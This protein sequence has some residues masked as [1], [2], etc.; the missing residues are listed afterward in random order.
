MYPI[1]AIL[2]V[3]PRSPQPGKRCPTTTCSSA[4][5]LLLAVSLAAIAFAWRARLYNRRLAPVTRQPRRQRRQPRPRGAGTNDPA[6]CA[7]PRPHGRVDAA[8]TAPARLRCRALR[9]RSCPTSTRRCSTRCEVP[10]SHPS[11]EPP[12]AAGAAARHRRRGCGTARFAR[13][14]APRCAAGRGGAGTRADPAV[15]HAARA[16]RRARTRARRA[17]RRSAARGD[18][19][20]P[21]ASGFCRRARSAFAAFAPATWRLGQQSALA[22]AAF[23]RKAGNCAP[24]AAHVLGL[25]HALGA[26]TVFRLALAHLPGEPESRA[27]SRSARAT[28]HGARRRGGACAGGRLEPA[29]RAALGSR[30]TQ[31]AARAGRDEPARARALRRAAARARPRSCASMARWTRRALASC[32]RARD[33]TTRTGSAPARGSP[34]RAVA[35]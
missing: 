18:R 32:W 15:G 22:A 13:G 30:G 21:A 20:R 24:V 28:G 4:S 35:R 6:R 17:R 27:A 16:R 10:R 2:R 34:P 26:V 7:V 31:R 14:A 25:V 11:P 23:A 29:G 1:A 3:P 12:C 33:S 19:E 5:W 8:R 9:P